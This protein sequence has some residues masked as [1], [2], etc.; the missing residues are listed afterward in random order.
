MNGGPEII[1][2]G[3]GGGAPGPV[4]DPPKGG[5]EGRITVTDGGTRSR[6]EK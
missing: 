4:F 5:G 6:P 1:G 3:A 2:P